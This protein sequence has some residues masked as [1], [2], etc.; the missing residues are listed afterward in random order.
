MNISTASSM[1][2]SVFIVC[3]SIVLAFDN[4]MV[5]LDAKSLLIVLGGTIT[6]TFTCFPAKK[7]LGLIKVF[8]KGMMGRQVSNHAEPIND[9]VHLSKSSRKGK[10]GL[11]AALEEIKHPFIR[12]GVNILFWSESDIDDT[13]LRDLLETRV[14]S[15]FDNY[16]QDAKIFSTIAKFP[17]A[18]GLMGT[19][20]GMIA[21]LQSIG[22][23]GGDNIGPSMAIALITT[24]YG[25]I[26]ANVFLIPISEHLSKKAEEE[27]AIRNMIIEAL[28]LIHKKYPTM[29]VQEKI[30][31]Y[32][33]PSQRIGTALE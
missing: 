10:A 19:T 15:L 25:L 2:G 1:F 33:L 11:K 8:I 12:E 7:V 29:F 3:I 18:F 32:L 9:L 26:L 31:S 14:A 27:L 16:S 23:E 28:L 17:P 21:L 22:G 6:A 30:R 20:I 13:D 4:P 24:L 5:A